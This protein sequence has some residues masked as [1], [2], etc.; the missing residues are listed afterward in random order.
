MVPQINST[1]DFNHEV[2]FQNPLSLTVNLLTTRVQGPG[3]EL[4]TDW[5]C[6]ELRLGLMRVSRRDGLTSSSCFL[7]VTITKKR[8]NSRRLRIRNDSGSLNQ[9]H[10]VNCLGLLFRWL[11][12]LLCGPLGQCALDATLLSLTTCCREVIGLLHDCDVERMPQ[13][14]TKNFFAFAAMFV[15]PMVLV[16]DL[17]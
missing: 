2:P 17:P 3:D 7:R 4:E 12:C 15:Q 5:F 10:K 11:L 14:Q 13:Q 8:T 16:L 9:E 6:C 1:E